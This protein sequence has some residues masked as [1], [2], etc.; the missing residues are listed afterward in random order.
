MVSMA[1]MVLVFDLLHV[2]FSKLLYTT[3]TMRH[4]RVLCLGVVGGRGIKLPRAPMGSL[5]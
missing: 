3:G 4:D 1:A 2:L 5:E